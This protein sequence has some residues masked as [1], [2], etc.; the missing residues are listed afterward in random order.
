MR[1]AQMMLALWEQIDRKFDRAKK[2]VDTAVERVKT[3]VKA[4][5][6]HQ[7]QAISN[8]LDQLFRL[9][10]TSNDQRKPMVSL[11]CRLYPWPRNPR[12]FGRKRELSE[13]NIALNPES[14]EKTHKSF[15][16]HGMGGVGK[17]QI[18]LEYAYQAQIY[19]EAIF[20]LSAQSHLN[21]ATG[22]SNIASTLGLKPKDSSAGY[23]DDLNLV[24][25]WMGET[26]V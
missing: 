3:A 16:I 10:S 19:F 4:A 2:K 1:K 21:L 5:Q 8:R 22:F 6:L 15:A 9:L 14:I 23:Q 18:A 13:I 24:H 26:G 11:P 7:D 20:W 17:T 25:R 12:F